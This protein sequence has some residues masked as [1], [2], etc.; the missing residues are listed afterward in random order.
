MR[1]ANT[2]RRGAATWLDSAG[3]GRVVSF[4]AEV[5]KMKASK[6]LSENVTYVDPEGAEIDSA[7]LRA[8]QSLEGDDTH[9][10]TDESDDDGDEASEPDA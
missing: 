4:A 8:D 3:A 7:M 5:S 6:W 1:G 10:D 2:G 9:S